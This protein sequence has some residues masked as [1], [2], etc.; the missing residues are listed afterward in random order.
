MFRECGEEVRISE[1]EKQPHIWVNSTAESHVYSTFI[2]QWSLMSYT[3]GLPF[4]WTGL[5]TFFFK[6]ISPSMQCT[7]MTESIS[8]D[9][10]EGRQW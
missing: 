5:M 10:C 1:G 8:E 2:P 6:F 4:Q 3:S 7:V 9:F